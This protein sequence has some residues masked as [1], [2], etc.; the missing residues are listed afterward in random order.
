MNNG[1]VLV[2][3]KDGELKYYKDGKFFDLDEVKFSKR[4][5]AEVNDEI[6]KP[7]KPSPR[8]SK[9]VVTPALP[10]DKKTLPPPIPEKRIIPERKV[11]PLEIPKKEKSDFELEKLEPSHGLVAKRES[12]KKLIELQ[13]KAV[14][15]KLKISFSNPKMKERFSGLLKTYFRGVRKRKEVE[16]IL[17]VKKIDG[18]LE[19][20]KEKIRLVIN[21][22]HQVQA[23]FDNERR[24][25]VYEAP[26]ERVVAPEDDLVP[27]VD[28]DHRIAPPPPAIKSKS[29]A[30]D[31]M[32]NQIEKE[33]AS[34][35]YSLE[36]SIEK[37]HPA[38]K[39][40][41][42]T[43]TESKEPIL[44]KMVDIKPTNRMRGPLEELAYMDLQNFRLLDDDPAE[45]AKDVLEKIALLADQGF[46]KKVEGINAWRNCPVVRIY[47][48]MSV[49]AI[50]EV[51]SIKKLI[52]KKQ[53]EN[54]D[55]LTLSEFETIANI[56]K[57]LVY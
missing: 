17:S 22:I 1:Y 45:A 49:D 47:K 15:D 11:V 53:R 12:D 50:R 30:F 33:A 39:I 46:P 41:R 24:K 21:V 51:I 16:Y 54:K 55:V 18:G 5:E 29:N 13:V 52:E 23:E 57:R 37:K 20:P 25:I 40:K 31:K 2:K 27:I 44:D 48:E 32:M 6:S 26:V 3:N 7:E 42:E 36:S 38:K 8:P 14:I 19:L 56:N 35:A 28:H 43:K 4:V 9:P 34:Q 10:E